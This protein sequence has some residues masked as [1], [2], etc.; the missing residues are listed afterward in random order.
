MLVCRIWRSVAL[1]THLFGPKAS[2]YAIAVESTYVACA[3]ESNDAAREET[4]ASAQ[5]TYPGEPWPM[6]R[7]IAAQTVWHRAAQSLAQANPLLASPYIGR[8]TS[9]TLQLPPY[10]KHHNGVRILTL[11]RGMHI[12]CPSS[13]TDQEDT[14][15]LCAHAIVIGTDR[16]ARTGAILT[17]VAYARRHGPCDAALTP[18]AVC[19]LTQWLDD[20]AQCD[21]PH[22]TMSVVSAYEI[23]PSRSRS[24]SAPTK[25][26][27]HLSSG[28]S[29]RAG[30]AL[31]NSASRRT[32]KMP[33]CGM[34]VGLAC[35]PRACW[36]CCRDEPT[37]SRL[38]RSFFSLFAVN[39]LL[40]NTQL[41]LR[42]W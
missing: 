6:M 35:V 2:A 39:Q 28:V 23:A 13:R 21:R 42:I 16:I 41:T 5:T 14:R 11:R 7:R 29:R 40:Q 15:G 25:S 19:S 8:L 36:P 3:V 38:K 9:F 26:A 4:R 12:C 32:K 24:P 34:R 31:S 1:A 10:V 30:P 18:Y 22:E 27:L 33:C 17:R 20:V 37:A